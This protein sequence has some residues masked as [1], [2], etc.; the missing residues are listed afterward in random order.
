MT[1]RPLEAGDTTTPGYR[2]YEAAPAVLAGCEETKIV[3][4]PDRSRGYAAQPRAWLAKNDYE[5]NLENGMLTKTRGSLDTTALL[6]FLSDVGSEAIKAAGTLSAL[7][8]EAGGA[9]REARLY[10]IEFDDGGLISG[11]RPIGSLGECPGPVAS[12]HRASGGKK[13][14]S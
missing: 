12:G 1:V 3:Y 2:F 5:L 14:G 13:K 6:S 8:A 11:L 10:V 7:S 4:L 9:R